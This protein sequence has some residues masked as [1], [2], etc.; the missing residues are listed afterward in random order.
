MLRF[1]ASML[2]LLVSLTNGCGGSSEPSSPDG[3]TDALV[4]G[5]SAGASGARIVAMVRGDVPDP[6]GITSL[7]NGLP[8][9]PTDFDIGLNT[10]TST[11]SMPSETLVLVLSPDDLQ[12]KL[13]RST[14]FVFDPE[15]FDL[16]DDD[17]CDG[18]Y[19]MCNTSPNISEAQVL[20][21]YCDYEGTL[22]AMAA[23]LDG[24]GKKLAL[25]P[26]LADIEGPNLAAAAAHV[27]LFNLQIP[28]F[29]G[30]YAA[31][32]TAAAATIRGVNPDA[33]VMVQ[34]IPGEAG[35]NSQQGTDEVIAAWNSVKD[36]VDGTWVFYY[37]NPDPV[38]LLQ[39]VYAVIRP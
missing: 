5:D 7:F 4:S 34:L 19:S 17:P 38:P 35:A 8:M 30:N 12:V 39:Q 37:S 25:T 3:S 20:A 27:D 32:V 24:T 6:T 23:I 36:V 26:I 28:H 11:A 22:A 2:L 15:C 13:D 29:V 14:W 18:S 9:L 33:I 10:P 31:R 16:N 1:P 21:Q